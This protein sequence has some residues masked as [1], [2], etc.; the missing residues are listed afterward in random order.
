[1]TFLPQMLVFAL[2]AAAAAAPQEVNILS[3]TFDQDDA[4][5]Y[6]FAYELDNGQRAD[7]AGKATAGAEPETGTIDVTG[8][9]T[10]VGDDGITYTVSYQANEA[11]FAPQAVHLPVAP[12]QIAEYAQLRQEHPELFWAESSL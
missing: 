4:G 9:Y 8:S 12:A 11:G 7:A 3:Q 1:M 5:N 6:N 10:F 2:V